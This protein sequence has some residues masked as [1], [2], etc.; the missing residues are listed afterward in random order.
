MSPTQLPAQRH[1]AC[2]FSISRDPEIM[3]LLIVPI[4]DFG[5]SSFWIVL[6]MFEASALNFSGKKT[7]ATSGALPTRSSISPIISPIA[8]AASE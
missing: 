4:E 1:M 8:N 7:T 3:E 5:F 2:P 6:T